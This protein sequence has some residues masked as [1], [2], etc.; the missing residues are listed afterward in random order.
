MLV[1]LSG[2]LRPPNRTLMDVF[3]C[4]ANPSEISAEV[5]CCMLAVFK[6]LV[7]LEKQSIRSEFTALLTGLIYDSAFEP[8]NHY[9]IN[10]DTW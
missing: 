4:Y 7:H 3:T 8:V 9:C 10:S 6:L 2:H 5:I 1:A